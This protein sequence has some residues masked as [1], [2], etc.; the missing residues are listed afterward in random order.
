M[1]D[2]LPEPVFDSISRYLQ[3]AGKNAS[4]GWE[5]NNEEEDSLTG[6]LGH[7]LNTGHKV[8]INVKGQYWRWCVRYKKFRG[9]GPAAFEH[10]MGAD[11]IIQIEVT[12]RDVTFFKGVLFQAKKGERLQNGDLKQQIE[13][14]EDF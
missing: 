9:R 11:G 6:D 4:Q 8:F 13:S 1:R 2:L 12:V 5:S 7:S 3:R 10:R 14:I